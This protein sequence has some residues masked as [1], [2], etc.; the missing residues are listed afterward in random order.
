MIRGGSKAD[1]DFNR[2]PLVSRHFGFVLG[3]PEDIPNFLRPKVTN[4]AGDYRNVKNVC[5][6]STDVAANHRPVTSGVSP[7]FF[8]PPHASHSLFR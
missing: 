3:N 4:R 6:R 7:T 2:L 1:Y 5:S 8:A